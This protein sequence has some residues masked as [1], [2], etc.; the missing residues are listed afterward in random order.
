MRSQRERYGIPEFCNSRRPLASLRLKRTEGGGGVAR[1]QKSGLLGGTQNPEKLPSGSWN[2]RGKVCLTEAEATEEMQLLSTVLPEA[3]KEK[4]PGFPPFLL[5]NFL[6]E[7]PV[8]QTQAETYWCEHLTISLHK[9]GPL[10]CRTTEE[11]DPK[12]AHLSN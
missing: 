5:S 8:G 11:R 2:H 7:L 1:S 9:S 3:E 12:P 6:P 10:K 4:Y